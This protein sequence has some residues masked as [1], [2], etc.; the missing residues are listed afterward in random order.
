MANI[1][2]DE[3][4]IFDPTSYFQGKTVAATNSNDAAIFQF[5]LITSWDSHKS[6]VPSQDKKNSEMNSHKRRLII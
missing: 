4:T 5:E 6:P 2:G 3:Q 1:S